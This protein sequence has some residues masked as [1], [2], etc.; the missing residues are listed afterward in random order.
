MTKMTDR[1]EKFFLWA[2]AGV[3]LSISIAAIIIPKGEDVLLINGNHNQFSDR[4][5]AI[6]TIGGEGQVFVP[7][8]LILLFVRFSYAIAAVSAWAGHGI[9]CSVLKK[10]VFP[11]MLRPTGT[12]DN[13]LLYFVPGVDVHSH[14]SFPSG[15]TATAFCFA[16]L[17]ALL[18]RKKFVFFVMIALAVMI[19]YSRV[20]LLQHF[21]MDVA[22][23]AIIGTVA[24]VATWYL[25]VVY[26]KKEWLG[27]KL[28]FQF[29][30]RRRSTFNEQRATTL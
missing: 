1:F 13:E 22:A 19:G 18:L 3:L 24:A 12:L 16:V 25:F 6:I 11:T 14:Y 2:I 23:G 27:R 9:L 10:L 26:G 8:I 15:H 28:E 7:L 21:L 17:V 5:F 4:F 29:R 30:R 20:Y